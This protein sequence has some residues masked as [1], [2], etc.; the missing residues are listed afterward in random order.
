MKLSQWHSLVGVGMGGF[1]CIPDLHFSLT[2]ALWQF[3]MRVASRILLTVWEIPVLDNI[4][5]I[6]ISLRLSSGKISNVDGCN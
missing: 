3:L 5:V 6:I 4:G 1:N 2:Q